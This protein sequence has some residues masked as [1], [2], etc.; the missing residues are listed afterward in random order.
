MQ[1]QDDRA[2]LAARCGSV[3]RLEVQRDG[4][5]DRLGGFITRVPD[6][7]HRKVDGAHAPAA[8]GRLFV[9]HG[10]FGHRR[11]SSAVARR[12]AASVPVGT[13]R[14]AL[15]PAGTTTSRPSGWR[16]ISW[17][18]RMRTCVQPASRSARITSRY[19]LATERVGG[20]EGGEPCGGVGLGDVVDVDHRRV[21]R[22]VTH[23]R[24]D[25]AERKGADGE[26]AEGVPQIVKDDAVL[27]L[28]QVPETGIA[29]RGVEARAQPAVVD[30]AADLV[31]EHEVARAG[32]PVAAAETIERPRD[33]VD[34][35]HGADATGLRPAPLPARHALAPRDPL[36][37]EVDVVPAQRAQL[38]EPQAAER[39]GEEDRRV[40]LVARGPRNGL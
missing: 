9:D 19:F 4:L 40:L 35:R 25:V 12:M 27:L 38:A 16:Q 14:L 22:L 31:A 8:V 26:R 6:G 10:V 20:Q 13:S 24:L 21:D 37:G 2:D 23:E 17:L 3:A 34:Q 5:P 39:G 29:Q 15:P 30:E 1:L 28:A 18:P 33:L 36:A 32:E 11:S 7:E